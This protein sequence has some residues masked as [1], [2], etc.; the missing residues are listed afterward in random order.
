MV[1]IHGG[2]YLGGKP[3]EYHEIIR[4]LIETSPC[5][6]LA[7]AYRNAYAAPFPAA[8]DDCADTLLWLRDNAESQGVRTTG[9]VVAGHSAGGGLTAAVT[10]WATDTGEVPIAFQMP[11]YPMID[12]RPTVSSTDNNAPVWNSTA[13]QLG[14]RTYHKGL[15]DVPV[16]AAPARATEFSRLPPTITFV[17][18]VEPFRDETVTY[19]EALRDAGV[20]VEFELFEGA[21]H[22]FELLS[23]ESGIGRRAWEFLLSRY[24]DYSV[25]YL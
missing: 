18:G 3:E 22:G 20:P 19:V 1:Y 17:G 5:V 6:I 7:P 16:Y 8:F 25:R 21:Y 10:A 13:N 2:G 15:T 24:Q 23:P 11:V 12:D 14:W 4:R 9:F